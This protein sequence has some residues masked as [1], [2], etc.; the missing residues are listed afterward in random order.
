MVGSKV[1]DGRQQGCVIVGR[2]I[3]HHCSPSLA[4]LFCARHLLSPQALS[5]TWL[6]CYR[7]WCATHVQVVASCS[8][9]PGAHGGIDGATRCALGTVAAAAAAAAASAS[10]ISGHLPHAALFSCRVIAAAAYVSIRLIAGLVLKSL[11]CVT[12]GCE[13]CVYVALQL[14][15]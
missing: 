2:E 14:N 10:S 13:H 6:F 9:P 12:C 3:I 15:M 4:I 8:T 7:P 1:S 11:S 5:T